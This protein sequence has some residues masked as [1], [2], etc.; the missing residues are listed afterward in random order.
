M[1]GADDVLAGKWD[2]LKGSVKLWWGDI[3]DDEL[4]MIDGQRDKLV[5]TLRERYGWTQMKAD[6]EVDRFLHD[7]RATV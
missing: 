3:T 7:V 4:D 1:A 5:G 6:A 2:Q